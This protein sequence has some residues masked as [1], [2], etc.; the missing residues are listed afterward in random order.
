MRLVVGS[1]TGRDLREI[2]EISAEYKIILK[3]GVGE[4]ITPALVP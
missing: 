2:S 4:M 3:S 1:I